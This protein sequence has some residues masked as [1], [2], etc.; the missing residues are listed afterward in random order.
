M[1]RPE[2]N[3][4]KDRQL[5]DDLALK[6]FELRRLGYI[7]FG[8]KQYIKDTSGDYRFLN[9][10]C[11]LTHKGKN[12]LSY[13]S[14]EAYRKSLPTAQPLATLTID[15]SFHN[16]GNIND[17]N[18]APHSNRVNQ[19]LDASSEVGQFFE[20]ITEALQQDAT[21]T[22]TQ[23]QEL[24]DDVKSLRKELQRDQPRSGMLTELYS[25]LGNTASIAAYLP[26]LQA[27]CGLAVP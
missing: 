5:F 14:Y 22:Q 11:N 8:E 17:S 2:S 16:S 12:I 7:E 4:A 20:K 3:H 6:V 13:G 1:L 23:L 24:L 9:I 15:Q 18:I 26:Q 21:L 10:V 27:L 19:T 25:M